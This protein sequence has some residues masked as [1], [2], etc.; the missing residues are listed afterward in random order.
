MCGYRVRPEDGGGDG[1]A[2]G[3]LERPA[4]NVD[5]EQLTQMFAPALCA[6]T[7]AKP[8]AYDITAYVRILR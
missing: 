4:I 7:F 8:A 5:G 1:R 3:Y 2:W 6:I